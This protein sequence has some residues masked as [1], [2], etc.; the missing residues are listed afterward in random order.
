MWQREPDLPPQNNH[1]GSTTNIPGYGA[2]V[3]PMAGFLPSS[4]HSTCPLAEAVPAMSTV[5]ALEDPT[6]E[7]FK[8]LYQMDIDIHAHK[9]TLEWVQ[10]ILAS[11]T[12]P[13]QNILDQGRGEQEWFAGMLEEIQMLRVPEDAAVA[14]L[15]VSMLQVVLEQID[16]LKRM[17]LDGTTPSDASG[18]ADIFDSRELTR[19]IYWLIIFIVPRQMNI[20]TAWTGDP[21]Y[22]PNGTSKQFFYWQEH[23]WLRSVTECMVKSK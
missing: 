2:P 1:A 7:A 9:S 14:H 11:K 8:I 22:L 13:S 18:V 15:K 21:Y 19:I 6:V 17:N 5:V 10:G 3:M 20:W 23:S 16:L 4:T 12:M